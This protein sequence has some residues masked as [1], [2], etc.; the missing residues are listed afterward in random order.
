ML[1]NANNFNKKKEYFLFIF[2]IFGKVR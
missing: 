1:S 2:Q